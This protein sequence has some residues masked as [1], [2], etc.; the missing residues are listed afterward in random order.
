M[1]VHDALTA[2]FDGLGRRFGATVLGTLADDETK[3]GEST[4]WPWGCYFLATVPDHSTAGAICDLVRQTRVGDHR[5]WRY[6]TIEAR[7]GGPL[8]FAR[9]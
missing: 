3:V 4:A 9:T 7:I 2:A 5:L 6:V 1:A 8:F